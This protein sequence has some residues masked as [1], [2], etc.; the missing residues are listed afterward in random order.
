MISMLMIVRLVASFASPRSIGWMNETVLLGRMQNLRATGMTRL[1]MAALGL[2]LLSTIG[3]GQ[4]PKTAN[5][6]F[7]LT[8]SEGRCIGCKTAAQLGRVQFISR[9][10]VWAVGVSVPHAA[11]PFI[12]VHSTDAGRTWREMPQTLQYPGAPDG[13]PAFSFLDP[14]RG[15][16]AW[17]NSTDDAP[18]MIS[19]RD[20]GKHWQSLS[21]Q[22]LQRMQMVDDSRGYGTVAES[23]F[24]TNDGGRS[25]VET[26]FPDIRFIHRLFFLTP[27][28]GWIAGAAG[29]D[30]KDFFVF[31]TANGGRDWE[32]SRT[33]PPEHP[34]QVRDLFFLDQLRGWLITWGD[35]DDGSYLYSTVDGGKHWTAGPDLSFEG[36]GKWASVVR[37]TSRERGFVFVDDSD[38]AQRALM[39][40][41]DG[42]THWHKQALRLRDFAYDCQ[43]FEGDLLCSADLPFRLLT[44]HPK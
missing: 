8:S 28:L 14:M 1:L 24:R 12:V 20:G 19:T 36:K 7:A 2:V 33:T 39:Y 9:K 18:E 41:L 17:W 23:F 6:P 29:V 43:V 22:F 42:G 16:I 38:N 32:E 30:G 35:N 31:R 21:Q 44:L 25:W 3:N 15:W 10:D 40:T 13:P 4:D 37:F 11:G 5:S 26:K 27:E 34:A